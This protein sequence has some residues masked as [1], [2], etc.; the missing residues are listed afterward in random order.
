MNCLIEGQSL[1]ITDE[2]GTIKMTMPMD[3]A[4]ELGTL[5]SW[6]KKNKLRGFG[7][8]ME[9]ATLEEVLQWLRKKSLIGG[10]EDKVKYNM[11]QIFIEILNFFFL[12][13]DAERVFCIEVMEDEDPR[14]VLENTIEVSK[15]LDVKREA[16]FVVGVRHQK[17]R[18]IIPFFLIRSQEIHKR[19]GSAA[20]FR[21]MSALEKMH[22]N[23]CCECCIRDSDVVLN[24]YLM[25]IKQQF[26]DELSQGE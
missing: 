25:P 23:L 11:V 4:I 20:E 16:A 8:G 22:R 17:K 6:G 3:N 13:K 24:F 19:C 21:V 18:E 26:A 1:G 15:A 10:V 2:Y 14:E 5:T 7:H 12:Q 9:V